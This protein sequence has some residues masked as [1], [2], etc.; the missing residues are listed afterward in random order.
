MLSLTAICHIYLR[1]KAMVQP[2]IRLKTLNMGPKANIFSLQCKCLRYL[3]TA[4]KANL[5]KEG[6]ERE[7][8]G[9]MSLGCVL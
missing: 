9:K 5:Y 2:S 6:G 8:V 1:A 7:N 3:I 4:W